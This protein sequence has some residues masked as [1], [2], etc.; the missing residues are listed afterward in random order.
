MPAGTSRLRPRR[1]ASCIAGVDRN[2]TAWTRLI[3]YRRDTPLARLNV[4]VWAAKP[5][6]VPST[7]V[8]FLMTSVSADAMAARD[9]THRL[10]ARAMTI[11]FI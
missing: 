2:S 7:R 1:A 6:T 11:R 8:P 9:T 4:M 10:I 3:A 5:T